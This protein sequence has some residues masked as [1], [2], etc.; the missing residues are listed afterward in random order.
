MP[1]K[2][3]AWTAVLKRTL[4]HETNVDRREA[5]TIDRLRCQQHP[6]QAWSCAALCSS[7]AM[8]QSIRAFVNSLLR[9]CWMVGLFFYFS[10]CFFFHSQSGVLVSLDR[11]QV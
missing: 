11:H 10:F 3:F 1:S 8:R 6:E 5:L 2:R 7:F 4:K 9:I